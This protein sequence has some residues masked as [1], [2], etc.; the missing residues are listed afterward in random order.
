MHHCWLENVKAHSS[1][2]R[3]YVR[4][5]ND[6]RRH[7]LRFRHFSDLD[8][9]SC[10]HFSGVFHDFLEEVFIG[11][12]RYG[13]RIVRQLSIWVRKFLA[14]LMVE[15]LMRDY[16]ADCHRLWILRWRWKSRW[17]EGPW[18]RFWEHDRFGFSAVGTAWSSF[19]LIMDN[20]LCT[21]LAAKTRDSRGN[22]N[23]K[24]PDPVVQ[25]SDKKAAGESRL[26]DPAHGERLLQS[27]SDGET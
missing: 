3:I 1:F 21:K 26:L 6:I 22:E 10:I 17:R 25:L 18:R 24:Q 2:N 23:F 16:L 4:F 11:P 15:A 9:H 20:P 14:C 27:F 13:H 19:V 8:S 7:K 12:G 5:A